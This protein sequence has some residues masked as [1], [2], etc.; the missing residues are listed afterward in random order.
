METFDAMNNKYIITEVDDQPTVVSMSKCNMCPFFSLPSGSFSCYCTKRE[1]ATNPAKLVETVN[2]ITI[3]DGFRYVLQDIK[4]PK[5]CELSI[6]Q[7]DT[8]LDNYMYYKAV[9][10]VAGRHVQDPGS[11]DLILDTAIKYSKNKLVKDNKIKVAKSSDTPPQI[12]NQKICSCCGKKKDD[13]IRSKN[14]G[15]CDDCWEEISTF[16]ENKINSIY[17]NNFRLKRKSTYSDSQF[18]KII[19]NI[20]I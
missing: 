16:D 15:M 1:S 12:D 17:I 4:Q 13:V 5:W 3:T 2:A 11:L 20:E 9:G 7:L 14:N 10:N 19:N 6:L 8:D 18:K